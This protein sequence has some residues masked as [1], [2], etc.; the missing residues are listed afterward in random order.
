L[1]IVGVP[2]VLL[3]EAE[4]GVGDFAAGFVDAGGEGVGVFGGVAKFVGGV[5]GGVAGDAAEGGGACVVDAGDGLEFGG[6]FGVFGEPGEAGRA[7]LKHVAQRDDGVLR[8]GE[9]HRENMGRGDGL[10]PVGGHAG[11]VARDSA[12]AKRCLC[13]T[14]KLRTKGD[15]RRH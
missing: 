15:V 12:A 11:I 1:L 5:E 2:G 4:G 6:G 7:D 14:T 3:E 8:L 10:G 9:G 13:M